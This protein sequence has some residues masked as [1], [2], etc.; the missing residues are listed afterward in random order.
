MTEDC[1]RE[2]GSY[3]DTAFEAAGQIDDPWLTTLVFGNIGLARLFSGDTTEA[4]AAFERQ[5][6]LC[7]EDAVH[8]YASEPIIGFAPVAAAGGHFD[9]AGSLL[10]AARACGYPPTEFDK[11]IY[12]RLEREYFADARN[13]HG[14]SRMAVRR[15][16]YDGTFV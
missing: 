6:Q 11:P 16:S 3:L 10:A 1:V 2:A 8:L 9:T 7:R 4:N 12:E 5:L 14:G 13:P 15:A